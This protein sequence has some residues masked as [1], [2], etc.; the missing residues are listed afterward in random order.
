MKL[1]F[2]GVIGENI[3]DYPPGMLKLGVFQTDQC[4]AH[5][6]VSAAVQRRKLHSYISCQSSELWEAEEIQ[7][8][9]LVFP[10]EAGCCV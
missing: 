4:G 1:K 5:C 3:I 6:G 2:N 7:K 10:V 9:Q 8:K